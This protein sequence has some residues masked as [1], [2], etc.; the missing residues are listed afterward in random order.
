MRMPGLLLLSLAVVVVVASGAKAGS[1]APTTAAQDVRL[2]GDALDGIHPG[3]YESVTRKRFRAEVD[4]LARSAPSLNAS[5]LLVG[6]MRIAALPGPRNGHTGLF[7]LDGAH[8]RALHLY[9]LRLYDFADG[10]FV[11]DTVGG[12]DL[13]GARVVAIEGVPIRRVLELVHPLVP[14]DNPSNLRGWAPHYALVAEV[15]DGLGIGSGLGPRRFELEKPGGEPF[16]VVLTPLSG[17]DY[18]SAFR[19]PL[20]GHYPAALPRLE[21]PLYLAQSGREL[22]VTKISG[23]RAVYVG[24]N[25]VTVPTV[26]A[27]A[28]VARLARSPGVRRVIVDVRLN[29]GG[30][31]T[32]YSALL[33]ALDSPRVN[34]RG[35]LYLLIGRATFSA[36]GN[37]VTEVERDTRAISVGEPTGGGVNI[38]SETS[39]FVLPSSGWS[40]RI[41]A[42][43]VQKGT[44]G[45]KRLT[46]MPDVRVDLTS[47]DFFARRDPVLERALA[48]L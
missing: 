19:D 6:L 32:T 47:G 13:I 16:D 37:F 30:D 39:S 21:R 40:V 29:G 3:L 43:Y 34:R 25:A 17:G 23:G 20:Y 33:G 2:L 41:A 7:P 5:E 4:R 42:G 46:N 12:A 10:L 22:W 15:L 18:V 44:P 31:N 11:I 1:S 14:R 36:A 27:A 9:P 28:R 8:R 26:E 35:R 48:G 38:Y 24:Y 45:D